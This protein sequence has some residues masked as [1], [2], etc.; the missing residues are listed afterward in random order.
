MSYRLN[1]DQVV[2]DDYDWE[3]V[4]VTPEY[5][6]SMA[7]H[8]Y[9]PF[10]KPVY[11]ERTESLVAPA[12]LEQNAQE[13]NETDG[14]RWSSGMGSEKGGNIPLIKVA[15]MPLNV[16]FAEIAPRQAAGDRD[17]LRWFL[18]RDE[19]APFRTRRGKI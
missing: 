8:S 11:I 9:D 10:G 4:E 14:T 7:V 1:A 6:R 16:F 18:N 17:F 13:R 3:V 12:L 15:S 19:N 5:R 2:N